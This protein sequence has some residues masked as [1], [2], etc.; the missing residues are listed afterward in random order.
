M[1]KLSR[2]SIYNLKDQL[3]AGDFTGTLDQLLKKSSFESYLQLDGEHTNHFKAGESYYAT[4]TAENGM[5]VKSETVVCRVA[6]P[7]PVFEGKLKLPEP[8]KG[9]DPAPLDSGYMDINYT[10]FSSTTF[11]LST[12]N[13]HLQGGTGGLIT[14]PGPTLQAVSGMQSMSANQALSSLEHGD[15]F[16]LLCWANYQNFGVCITFPVQ[17][18]HIGKRPYWWV[19]ANGSP[20]VLSGKSPADPYTFP[21]SEVPWNIV[22]QPTSE[23]TSLTVNVTITTLNS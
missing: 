20:W 12:N 4:G 5:P 1:Q 3:V 18:V 15:A 7:H 11:D 8:G 10:N 14:A 19:S 9:S 13:Y 17:V 2:V 22:A 6:G 21:T 16:I 23:H